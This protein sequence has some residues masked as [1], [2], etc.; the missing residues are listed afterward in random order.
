MN[1]NCGTHHGGGDGSLG[2]RVCD[3]LPASMKP[4]LS[5]GTHAKSG[6]QRCEDSGLA[7]QVAAGRTAPSGQLGIVSKRD[8]DQMIPIKGQLP[9][10]P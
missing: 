4:I 2:P 9:E 8:I 6:F 7:S 5:L 10:D 3:T 1:F